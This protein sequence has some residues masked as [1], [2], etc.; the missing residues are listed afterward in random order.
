MGEFLGELGIAAQPGDRIFPDPG[1]PV[2][3]SMVISVIS[4]RDGVEY[5]EDPLRVRDRLHV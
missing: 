3:T 2:R 4:F 1:D 5:T